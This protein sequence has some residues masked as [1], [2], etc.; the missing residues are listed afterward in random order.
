MNKYAISTI[1]SSSRVLAA[2][3]VRAIISGTT[4][5]AKSLK[6]NII[7]TRIR[8]SLWDA[9]EILLGFIMV[10]YLAGAVALGL[11]LLYYTFAR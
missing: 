9:T 7:F 10:L 2:D 3:G 8:W 6:D 11:A 4:K 5:Y 1:S